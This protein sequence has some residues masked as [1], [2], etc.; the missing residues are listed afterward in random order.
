MGAAYSSLGGTRAPH[1][2]SLQYSEAQ[3]PNSHEGNQAPQLLWKKFLKCVDPNYQRW[4]C[5]GILLNVFQSMVVKGLIKEYLLDKSKQNS[6][7]VSVNHYI[8]LK[9]SS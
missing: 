5:Q 2:T 6:K 8:T 3:R 1:A 7:I 4:L 9:F